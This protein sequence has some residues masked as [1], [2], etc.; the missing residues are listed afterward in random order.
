MHTVSNGRAGKPHGL[1]QGNPG[2]LQ[3]SGSGGRWLAIFD[4]SQDVVN[5]RAVEPLVSIPRVVPVGSSIQPEK[6]SQAVKPQFPLK[7]RESVTL[8]VLVR[9][10]VDG[11][12]GRTS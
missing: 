1:G 12:H 10:S 9:H 2:K 11:D 7:D 3:N 5:C 6:T 4:F 8:E